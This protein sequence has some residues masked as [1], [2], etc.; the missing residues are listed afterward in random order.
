MPFLTPV[1]GIKIA[2]TED[3]YDR[4]VI[5]SFKETMT[6]MQDQSFNQIRHNF[7]KVVG[8]R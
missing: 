3:M 4:D 6:T 1:I 2:S 8:S 5:I 7:W